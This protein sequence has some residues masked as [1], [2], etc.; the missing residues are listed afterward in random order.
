LKLQK[1]KQLFFDFKK[2]WEAKSEAVEYKTNPS[3][4]RKVA[5]TPTSALSD[6]KANSDYKE[7]S[8][9]TTSVST[10]VATADESRIEL[11]KTKI[12]LKKKEDNIKYLKHHFLKMKK[13]S[14]ITAQNMLQRLFKRKVFRPAF[15]KLLEC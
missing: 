6:V 13:K 9:R 15:E 1:A 8:E 10:V 3:A 2:K 5:M 4:M 7:V 12:Q 11:E 14:L